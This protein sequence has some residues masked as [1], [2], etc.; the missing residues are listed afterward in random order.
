MTKSKSRVVSVTI[1]SAIANDLGK[2]Q[3]LQKR[4]LGELGCQACCSGH[5]IRY[6]IRDRFRVDVK[7]Q[8]V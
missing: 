5:D 1:P 6:R 7:G 3:D 2:F 8:F 4:I